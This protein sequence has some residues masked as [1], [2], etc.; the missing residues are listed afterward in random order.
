[1]LPSTILSKSSEPVSTVLVT[2][3]NIQQLQTKGRILVELPGIEIKRVRK[4]LQGT[5]NLELETYENS[6]VYSYLLEANKRLREVKAVQAAA[7]PAIPAI[8][9]TVAKD[10]TKSASS[11]VSEI[12]MQEKDSLAAGTT[13]DIAKNYPLFCSDAQYLRD[14]QIARGPIV[15]YAHMKDTAQVNTYL[16]MQQ[17]KSVFPAR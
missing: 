8:T 11:L 16:K 3:P 6:E 15:G 14:G 7:T 17:V 9:A 13:E 12:K 2:Q 4:L 1:M 10:T 5:A